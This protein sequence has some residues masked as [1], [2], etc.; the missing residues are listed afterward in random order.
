MSPYSYK[1]NLSLSRH[2]RPISGGAGDE[3]VI[4]IAGVRDAV[5][6]AIS[7]DSEDS[8]DSNICTSMRKACFYA[9]EGCWFYKV[10]N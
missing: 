3:F 6:T 10:R 8:F 5:W 7:E 4:F 1:C 2:F 9:V